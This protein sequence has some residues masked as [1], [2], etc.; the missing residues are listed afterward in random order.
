MAKDE[1]TNVE[2]LS[3]LEKITRTVLYEGYAIFPYRRS[4]AKNVKP[5]PF[6]TVYPQVY[7]KHHSEL[8]AATQT[9]CILQASEQAS[10]KI[11]VRFLH[12][13]RKRLL[14]IDPENFGQNQFQSR[15][16]IEIDD[17]TYESG[18]EALEREIDI[19]THK[20]SDLINEPYK[21][22]IHFEEEQTSDII[23][24]KD[25]K[26]AGNML[27]QQDEING[28]LWITAKPAGIVE[29]GY[30]ITVNVGNTTTVDN[31]A[32]CSRDEVYGQSFLSANTI[33]A[34]DQ[35]KFISQTDPPQDWREVNEA[36]ENINTW[37][38]LIDKNNKTMLSSPIVLYD[39]PEIA[40]ESRGINFDSTEIEEMLMLQV[41]ALTDEEKQ[42]VEQSD[43]KM[44]AML[45]RVK[46]TTPGELLKLHGGFKDIGYR[47][48][49]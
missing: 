24:D 26:V 37:P 33:L 1:T 32:G 14:R 18:W 29:D 10:V 13:R 5:I 36:C 6:G 7:Q 39:Y 27:F 42:E 20:L 46:N 16:I 34:T 22:A 2:E 44:K 15:D 11:T 49:N 3:T 8:H 31:A 21:E 9:Q 23:Y 45:E 28:E 4:S 41:A 47:K 35:G 48:K 43:S 38:V 25:G 30:M 12:L 40:P 19:G 17:Q